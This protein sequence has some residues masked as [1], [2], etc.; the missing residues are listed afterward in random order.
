MMRF[1]GRFAA[2]SAGATAVLIAFTGSAH[3]DAVGAPLRE[4]IADLPVAEENRSGYQRDYFPHWTDVD[5]DGCNARTEVLMD[6][7]ITTPEVHE[8]CMLRNGRWYSYYDGVVHTTSATMDM[9]HFVPLAEAWD[10]GASKWD[11][12]RRE[13]FA[14]DIWDPRALVGVT[15]AQNVDKGGKDPADWLPPRSS[16]HCRY[17]KEWAAVKTRWRLSVDTAEKKALAR[18]AGECGPTEVRVRIAR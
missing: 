8:G 6:E 10:S 4:V 14:N 17:V 12:K 2:A 18:I 1:S 5:G 15:E 3:A 16:V 9:D 11:A 7:A 13:R